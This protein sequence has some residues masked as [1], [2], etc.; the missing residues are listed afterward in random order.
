MVE[1][2]GIIILGIGA[3]WLSWKLKLPAILPLIILG[4]LVGPI[5]TLW[6]AGGEKWLEPIYNPSTGVGIFPERYFFF[7]VSLSI[8]IILFEGGL[9]LKRKEIKGLG[10]VILRLISLGSLV[11][12][13]GAGIATYFLLDLN[14]SVAFLIGALIIV[15]GPT[16]IAPILQN[17]PLKKNISTTLKWEGIIIDPIGAFV[18]VLVF[19]FIISHSGA[20]SFTSHALLS[21]AE[22]VLIG[23]ALGAIAGYFLFYLV[24]KDL[25]PHFLLNVIT[26]AMVLGVFVFSDAV[27]EE[28]GLLAVVVMGT[29]LGNLD[30]PKLRDI[31]DFKE[32]L[33]I[34]LISIL[35][36][37]L[38]AHINLEDLELLKN[39]RSFALLGVVIVLLR[40][41]GVFL[42]TRGSNLSI[43]EKLLISFVGPRGIVAAGIASLFGLRLVK[44]NIAD[45]EY[46]TPLVFMVVLGT[47]L[48]TATATRPL[49]KLLKVLLKSS[50]GILIIGARLP[51]RLIGK[52]LQE[53]EKVVTLIDVNALNIQKAQEDGLEG[54]KAD[55]F[56]DDIASMASLQ[57]MSLLFAITGSSEVNSHACREYGKFF[58]GGTYQISTSL[59]APE[60]DPL[61]NTQFPPF[62]DHLTLLDAARDYPQI[63]EAPAATIDGLLD[64]LANIRKEKSSIPL[65]IWTNDRQIRIIPN[66]LSNLTFEEGDALV[67]LGKKM[68]FN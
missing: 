26:L 42:S 47:V 4:L 13:I 9:T 57:N 56:H 61:Q 65:L 48:L 34:L 68:V 35:F 50:D 52:Y 33:S 29:V 28:S 59:H 32:S 10:P 17:I 6:T 19:E 11:T 45:A 62:D 60:S 55:V 8:G 18:S 36:I 67:Y 3:Q 58:K 16:V 7:F 63:H 54:V 51:A 64:T 12:F 41:L 49:A 46:I 21:F 14:L 22:I 44:E 38:A 2:A 24:K 25:I 15:T 1:L 5:S 66:D 31:L 27:A 40:P 39:W 43:N 20:M 23:L 53:K 37:V 30:M